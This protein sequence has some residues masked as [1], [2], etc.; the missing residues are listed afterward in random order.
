MTLAVTLD[1]WMAR[2]IVSPE[3]ELGETVAFAQ[4]PRVVSSHPV[5]S[6]TLSL[7]DV[8]LLDEDTTALAADARALPDV[9]ALRADGQLGANELRRI[10]ANDDRRAH[11]C[12]CFTQDASERTQLLGRVEEE[13]DGFRQAVGEKCA[14]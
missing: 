4:S 8:S 14:G 3:V 10:L 7:L 1:K 2:R 13:V 9:E 5:S 12:R 6:H 11:G